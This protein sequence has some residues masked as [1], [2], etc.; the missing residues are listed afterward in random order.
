MKCA[1]AGLALTVAIYAAEEIEDLGVL[2]PNKAILLEKDTTRPDWHHFVAEL[3][4]ALPPTNV[5]TLILTNE[6]LTL[7]NLVALP[8]GPTLLGLRSA[9]LDDTQSATKLFKFEIRRDA[10]PKPKARMIH[11]LPTKPPEKDDVHKAL[12]RQH[13]GQLRS[14]PPMPGQIA[15]LRF[16]GPLP[17]ATNQSYAQHLDAM[18]DFY[19]SHANRRRNE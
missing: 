3:V 19:A 1:L 14:P 9:C 10:P 7:S 5:V 6:Y 2:T 15:A 8:S 12:Q 4:P 16:P 11:V 18:A 17:H 13:S